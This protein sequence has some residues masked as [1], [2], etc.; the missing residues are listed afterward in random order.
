MLFPRE[1]KQRGPRRRNGLLLSFALWDLFRSTFSPQLPQ[2]PQ[3][4]RVYG[5]EIA[6][7][8]YDDQRA[9]HT[10]QVESTRLYF[11][12]LDLVDTRPFCRAAWTTG[13]ESRLFHDW[14]TAAVNYAK[15]LRQTPPGCRV[16]ALPMVYQVVTIRHVATTEDDDWGWPYLAKEPPT[17][18]RLAIP[19]VLPKFAISDLGGEDLLEFAFAVH[20]PTAPAGQALMESY[21]PSDS[22]SSSLRRNVGAWDFHLTPNASQY[23]FTN[24]VDPIFTRLQTTDYVHPRSAMFERTHNHVRTA[25]RVLHDNMSPAS[26]GSKFRELYLHRPGGVGSGVAGCFST[27]AD[28]E[29]SFMTDRIVRV[30]SRLDMETFFIGRD[31][32]TSDEYGISKPQEDQECSAL[33]MS[34]DKCLQIPHCDWC[35]TSRGIVCSADCRGQYAAPVPCGATFP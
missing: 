9:P 7:F 25:D 12:A 32:Y 16:H 14:Q 8:E 1:D 22:L 34:C 19:R 23:N 31:H 20:K 18:W 4:H 5:K 27:S 29:P 13:C 2:L 26:V 10:G 15:C 3:L 30:G 33:S 17:I 28:T 24:D 21:C 11:H 6:D 35:A